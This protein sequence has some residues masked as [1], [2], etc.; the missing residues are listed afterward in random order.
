MRAHEILFPREFVFT[1]FC[2][3]KKTEPRALAPQEN[4][5]MSFWAARA[6]GA[7]AHCAPL[8]IPMVT[9][10]VT[11]MVPSMVSPNN[12]PHSDPVGDP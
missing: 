8:V 11:P 7:R 10:M 4:V 5:F 12:E 1:R 6:H 3:R 9:Y 2:E